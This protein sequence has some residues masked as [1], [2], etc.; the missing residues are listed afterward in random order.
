MKKVV[1]AFMCLFFLAGCQTMKGLGK[2]MEK[3]GK[4]IEKVVDKASTGNKGI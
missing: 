3:A 1:V 2:D 4:S